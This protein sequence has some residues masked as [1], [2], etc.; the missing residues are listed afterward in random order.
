[1]LYKKNS[2]PTLKQELFKNPTSEYRGTPFWAWNSDLKKEELCRQIDIFKRM[3]LGGFHMH[4]RT[5]LENE[6]LSDE[7]MELICACV[8]KAEKENMLAWLYDEDRWASGAAGGIVTKNHEYRIR[9]IAFT[10]DYEKLVKEHNEKADDPENDDGIEFLT[11]YDIVLDSEG[12]LKSFKQIGKD[13]KPIGTKWYVVLCVD[14]PSSWFNNQTYVDTLNPEAIKEFIKVTHERY[15]EC[16]GHQFDK[17]IPAIFTDEPQVRGKQ[18]IP[19]SF[20]TEYVIKMPW[21][22]A[23][24]D[25][26]KK[27]YG[28]DV[29][30]HLPEIVWQT[31]AENHTP[32]RYYY[33]DLIADMFT[34]AFSKTIGEWCD[35]NKIS[36]TGHMMA[37]ESLESQTICVSEAMRGYGYYGLPGIDILCN[38][39][40][41]STAKQCQSV[42]HQY[43]K[44]G[45]LSELYGVT[46]WSCDFRTYKFSGDWQAALGV[47][48][49]VPHL[50]WYAM[51]GEAKRDYP[52]SISYQ[53]PWFEKYHLVEDHFSRL[54]TALTRGKPVVKVAVIHPIESFWLNFGPNDKTQIIRRTMEE[55]FQNTVKWLIEGSID[56]DFI[57]EALLPFLCEKGSAPFKVG[58]MSYDAVVVPACETLRSSTIERLTQFKNDGGKLIFMGSAPK[59]CDAVISDKGKKL[60]LESECID[61]SRGALLTALDENR[62]LAIR[63]SNGELAYSYVYQ[64]RK[65]NDGLWLFIAKNREPDYIDT[66]DADSLKITVKGEYKAE[67][68]DTQNGEIYPATVS[69]ENGNTVI[70]K[71]MF[72]YDSV[73]FKLIEGKKESEEL[74][75]LPDMTEI[76]SVPDELGATDNYYLDEENVLV[77]DMAMYSIDGGEIHEREEILRLDNKARDI[78]GIPQ[79]GGRVCQP[80]VLGKVEAPHTLTLF[81]DFESEIEYQGAHLAL[82][83]SDKAKIVFNGKE[84]EVKQIGWYIDKKIHKISLGDIKKGTNSLEATLPLG[85]TTNTEN[86]FVLGDFGVVLDGQSAKI[87]EMP[88][89][90]RFGDIT[91]QGFP[92]YGGNITY[93]LSAEVEDDTLNIQVPSYRGAVVT[94]RIDGKEMGDIVYPPYTLTVNG[95]S[96]GSH[97]VELKLY[98]HRYNTLGPLHLM[99]V[100]VRWHGPG[101]WRSE[102]DSWKYEYELR[103][104]GILAAPKFK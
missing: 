44:E 12:F 64:L 68:W 65:D 6:Y 77:L 58:E 39:R 40:E 55:N 30:E 20:D 37:E 54:N 67:V 85:E 22:G 50:S 95:L 75:T 102:G 32:H 3:G 96:K 88:R 63:K 66:C 101:A 10:T 43:G 17:V 2:E 35:E 80:W 14:S 59:Y 53:S 74:K 84:I 8:D 24:P 82:E 33:H 38:S 83:D 103:P 100:S 36:L 5:G 61:I 42:V 46:S 49:R 79:R 25:E 34:D 90:I 16:C 97:K 87:V 91:T 92:F 72:A 69:Y 57:S 48:V 104:A 86:M 11:C 47:T 94:V 1:M 26:Y 98:T 60:W 31:R 73:L 15:K 9:T 99:D 78:V 70:S 81:F 21:T 89:H 7:F 62:T 41:F 51:Q 93:K 4:V 23:F 29:F 71:E 27:K 13:D 45:M 76:E 28:V 52:A 19:N 18:K 56:F